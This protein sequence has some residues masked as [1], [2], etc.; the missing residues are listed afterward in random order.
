MGISVI[1]LLPYCTIAIIQ[2]V[3]GT[4]IMNIVNKSNNVGIKLF[5]FI[6]SPHLFIV[7]VCFIA[8]QVSLKASKNGHLVP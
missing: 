7:L 6:I 1:G 2:S 8:E 3:M 4:A 5:L